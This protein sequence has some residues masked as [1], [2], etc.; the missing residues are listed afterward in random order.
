M[1]LGKEPYGR[2]WQRDL[3]RLVR[4]ERD[5]ALAHM[6]N[7]ESIQGSVIRSLIVRV[8]VQRRSIEKLQREIAK[9]RGRLSRKKSTRR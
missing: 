6:K 9:L 8:R 7:M 2:E 4:G 3:R 1:Q 5:Q